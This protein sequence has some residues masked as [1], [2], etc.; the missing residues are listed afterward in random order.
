MSPILSFRK[1]SVIPYRTVIEIEPP[2]PPTRSAPPPVQEPLRAIDDT[3]K[4][5]KSQIKKSSQRKRTARAKSRPKRAKSKR[6]SRVNSQAQNR[7]GTLDGAFGT[8]GSDVDSDGRRGL[9]KVATS[10]AK[11]AKTA[12]SSYSST[13][14]KLTRDQ[15][16]KMLRAHRKRIHVCDQRIQNAKSESSLYL[17]VAQGRVI[18]VKLRSGKGLDTKQASS[19]RSCYQRAMSRV[20]SPS[21]RSSSRILK[22]PLPLF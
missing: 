22:L 20:R 3:V 18:I 8:K 12:K 2:P 6:A 17:K 7:D 14:E 13:E 11:T 16:M 19:L 10:S 1:E 9:P 15:V 5:K 4:V 21:S